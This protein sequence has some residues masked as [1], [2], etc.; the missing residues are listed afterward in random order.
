MR[1][2]F[3]TQEITL[4]PII[5]LKEDWWLLKLTL[6]SRYVSRFGTLSLGGKFKEGPSQAG[7]PAGGLVMVGHL[8]RPRPGFFPPHTSSGSEED[9]RRGVSIHRGISGKTHHRTRVLQAPRIPQ[10]NIGNTK[11]RD[12]YKFATRRGGKR[13]TPEQDHATTRSPKPAQEQ[14]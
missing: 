10:S 9:I 11:A 14:A 5:T 4:S 8:Q 2:R 7:V 6:L 3:L 13:S 12:S 1:N